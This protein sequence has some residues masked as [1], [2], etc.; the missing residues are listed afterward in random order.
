MEEYL[1]VGSE[2]FAG[3]LEGSDEKPIHQG[4]EEGLKDI[5]DEK[6]FKD[7]I[8][9]VQGMIIGASRT[10][11]DNEELSEEER[12]NMYKL[13]DAVGACGD[14]HPAL[15]RRLLNIIQTI[16][17]DDEE[18]DAEIV[19][20]IKNELPGKNATNIPIL[21]RKLI[22]CLIEFV[23][24]NGDCTDEEAVE[25]LEHEMEKMEFEAYRMFVLMAAGTL[26]LEELKD[27]KLDE[28]NRTSINSSSRETQDTESEV[29]QL[30]K[31]SYLAIKHQILIM[32]A[33]TPITV[34]WY[35]Y[36]GFDP[37]KVVVKC[38]PRA[39]LQNCIDDIRSNG[40]ALWE[41]VKELGLHDAKRMNEWLCYS[42]A[43][44]E[45]TYDIPRNEE[46]IHRVCFKSRVLLDEDCSFPPKNL[47]TMVHELAATRLYMIAIEKGLVV[48]VPGITTLYDMWMHIL[49]LS[50]TE[51]VAL[52]VNTR[53]VRV[54][55]FLGPLGVVPYECHNLPAPG[56]AMFVAVTFETRHSEGTRFFCNV[57][58]SSKVV[59]EE[60]TRAIE[61]HDSEA[62]IPKYSYHPLPAGMK[63][64]F[65]CELIPWN[66][67]PECPRKE[68]D[69][70][71]K[72]E[73]VTNRHMQRF[74]IEISLDTTCQR[75]KRKLQSTLQ[76]QSETSMIPYL[77]HDYSTRCLVIS[78]DTMQEFRVACGTLA[79]LCPHDQ[80]VQKRKA[81]AP[82]HGGGDSQPKIQ[83]R[84][85]DE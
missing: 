37:L 23:T 57:L 66:K 59:Q 52:F 63:S 67:F 25:F 82:P 41:R 18:P 42:I 9:A 27:C 10:M 40:G 64:N 68:E 65:S 51:R 70:M 46:T 79:R 24:I 38:H 39:T 55:T 69:L 61:E 75:L 81:E 71:R 77:L 78:T 72:M 33:N 15:L 29:V 53:A 44:R 17:S 80:P 74:R 76:A 48:G 22:A 4:V 13:I 7:V 47:E 45:D 32:G 84:Q 5:L 16:F 1:K 50:R 62:A 21:L 12:E 30:N 26:F 36:T 43:N 6:S 54:P 31:A 28:W 2:K 19:K 8:Q 14:T 83:K 60:V 73:I 3:S 20:R 34:E 49:R 85:S 35:E 56:S 11:S 58:H